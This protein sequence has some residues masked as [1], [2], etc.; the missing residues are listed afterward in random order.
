VTVVCGKSRLQFPITPATTAGDLIQSASNCFSEPIDP[1]TFVLIELFGKVGVQR[2]LR[3][4][5][6]IREV[7]NS[8]DEDQRDTLEVMPGNQ[9][10]SN[11]TLLNS[12][13]APKSQPEAQTFTLTYSH[14]VGKWDER[15][16]TLKSDGQVVVKKNAETADQYYVNVCHL[17]DFDV[18]MPT[19]RQ[20]SRKV[21]PP[22]KFCFAIKSQ[23]KT[24]MFEDL[25]TYVH[26]FCTGE[27][28]HAIGFYTAVQQWRSWYLMNI[29][30]EKAKV[31]GA[32]D[33][34]TDPSEDAKYRLGTFIPLIN[35]RVSAVPSS[36]TAPRSPRLGDDEP[37]VNMIGKN[38]SV[39]NRK[40]IDGE[41]AHNLVDRTRSI[42]HKSGSTSPSK[43]N[44]RSIVG[45]RSSVDMPRN[46]TVPTK[47]LVDLTPQ[48]QVPPQHQPKGRGFHPDNI[49]AGG[50][51]EAATSADKTLT[52][53]PP[54]SNTI[55]E[56]R[57]PF[58]STAQSQRN[59][60]SSPQDQPSTQR[61]PSTSS[62]T[63][64]LARHRSNTTS[65]PVTRQTTNDPLFPSFPLPSAVSADYPPLLSQATRS[66]SN[67]SDT[68]GVGL[69]APVP[70]IPLPPIPHQH[71]PLLNSTN[72]NV[73]N[74]GFIPG[75]LLSTANVASSNH[76]NPSAGNTGNGK[77]PLVEF[78]SGEEY[79]P[80]SLLARQAMAEHF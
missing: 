17:S 52:S 40:S 28:D 22:Q 54:S 30:R 23:Q 6:Y 50:L 45:Q 75:G 19:L 36:I 47:P 13:Q 12:S 56:W 49:G 53:P 14:K 59:I 25:S 11:P 65:Q 3:R 69:A 24:A 18:Y 4:Y 62:Q 55:P 31:Q 42:E 41:N 27:K 73:N 2:P 48:A 32:S 70:T 76:T 5:E 38:A 58:A 77:R 66:F 68:L 15:C 64:G 26:F 71:N 61:N 78:T 21:R 39:D 29:V 46:N 80:G 60:H 8:W 20:T 34:Q 72:N 44:S 7:L 74:D 16:V 51:I 9:A 63:A 35:A 43:R 57:S 67:G 10:G 1:K 37:L 79:V 33:N